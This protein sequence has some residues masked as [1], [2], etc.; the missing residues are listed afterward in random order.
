MARPKYLTNE[1]I[2]AMLLESDF[3]RDNDSSSSS[4]HGEPI[5]ESG[6]NDSSESDFEEE[7]DEI[8]VSEL[9]TVGTD[10]LFIS[11]DGTVWNSEP[12]KNRVGRFLNENVFS[13]RPGTT[14]FARARVDCFKDAFLPFF[15]RVR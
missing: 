11:K 5:D 1:E 4:N 13:I 7:D 2:E 6:L 9:P 15:W 10:P 8:D 14:R 3:E 12:T